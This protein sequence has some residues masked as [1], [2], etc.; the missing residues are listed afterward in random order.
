[1]AIRVAVNGLGRTGRML[2]RARADPNVSLVDLT[3]ELERAT[4]EE[5]VNAAMKEPAAGPLAGILC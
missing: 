2:V 5:A 3:V 1:M 4:T